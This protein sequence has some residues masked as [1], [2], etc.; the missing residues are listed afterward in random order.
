MVLARL[1]VHRT[2]AKP[3]PGGMKTLVSDD[4]DSEKGTAVMQDEKK[5]DALDT[6]GAP[7]V[8]IDDI[9]TLERFQAHPNEKS[10]YVSC[11]TA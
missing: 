3:G 10:R 1:I 6:K 9:P 7:A 11:C 4:T 8:T 5:S 2:G